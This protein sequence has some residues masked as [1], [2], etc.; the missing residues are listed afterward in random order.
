MHTKINYR[1]AAG[2]IK[3]ANVEERQ[4]HGGQMVL[5]GY[6]AVYNS[7]TNLGRF[8]EVILPGA[9]DAADITDAR[10]LIDHGGIPLGRTS[11]G[12]MVLTPDAR[13][14]KYSVTLPETARAAEVY[15]A[16]RRGDLSQSSFAFTIAAEDWQTVNGRK[17]RYIERVGL[18]VDASVVTY[19][20]YAETTAEALPLAG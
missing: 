3:A 8:D 13:G 11:S 12:T 4:N 5:E 17:T 1:K 10:F 20:A 14:L 7:F 19:P 9:F 18:V 2:L 6:A 15:E 16:V